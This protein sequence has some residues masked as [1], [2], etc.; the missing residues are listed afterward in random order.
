[1]LGAITRSTDDGFEIIAATDSELTVWRSNTT[2]Y[3][4]SFTA[5]ATCDY[6]ENYVYDGKQHIACVEDSSRG[7]STISL[8]N[9]QLVKQAEFSLPFEVTAMANT[10]GQQLLLASSTSLGQS[11]FSSQR[12]NHLHLY[13]P[14][15]GAS[16]WTSAP[17]IGE[18][19]G[20]EVLSDDVTGAQKIAVSTSSAMYIAR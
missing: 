6:L 11:Y 1:M 17:L 7:S 13:D 14:F 16:V 9:T 18:I 8:F 5:S 19:N 3:V 4:K 20:I 2:G 10:G 15:I 12:V